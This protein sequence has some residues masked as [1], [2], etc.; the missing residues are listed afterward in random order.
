M[1]TVNSKKKNHFFFLQCVFRLLADQPLKNVTISNLHIHNTVGA[2]ALGS[3]EI[4]DAAHVSLT[5]VSF[6]NNV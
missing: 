5:D 4:E 3:L 2:C 1:A 6:V